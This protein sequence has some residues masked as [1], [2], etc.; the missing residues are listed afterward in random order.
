M[1]DRTTPRQ[2]PAGDCRPE[3]APWLT[4]SSVAAATPVPADAARA[5]TSRPDPKARDLGASSSPAT[6][7]ARGSSTSSGA[8]ADEFI[9]LHGDRLFGD[10]EGDRDGLRPDRRR[11]V[12]VVGQQKGA[13]TEE[14]IRRNFGMPH[15]RATA[16]RCGS[17]SWRSGSAYRS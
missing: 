17:W 14:N 13:D 2:P 7:A 5:T 9:E 3:E 15:R 10:G 12:V 8:M 11:R 16:R 6:C 4:G 1:A